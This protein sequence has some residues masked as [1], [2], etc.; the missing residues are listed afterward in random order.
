MGDLRKLKVGIGQVQIIEGRASANEAAVDRMIDRALDAGADV[1]AV[2]ASLTDPQNVRLIGLNDSRID[3]AGNVVV[4]EACGESYRI[5][6]GREVPGC[7]FTLIGDTRPYS[8]VGSEAP[9]LRSTLVVKPVG[10]RDVGGKVFAFDGGSAAYDA[11]GRVI[12]RLSDGFEEDFALV[13]LAEGGKVEGATENKPLEG[14]VATMRRFDELVMP[15]KPKWVIGLSGGLDSSVTASLLV[16]A[17]GP[18]RV[19]GY[20]LATRFNSDATKSNA[21]AIAETLGIRMRNGSIE[22]L[23]VA[24]GNTAVQ[25]GYAPD[26]LSGLVLENA[27]ARTRAQLLSTFAALEGGVVVNNG[28]RVECA[29]GYA[30]LYGD[31]IG[32][33]CPI[34]DL[35]KVQLFDVARALNAVFGFEA[36]PTNLLPV[37]TPDG[38]QWATMPSAELASGQVDPMKWFYHDWLVSELQG[39]FAPSQRTLDEAACNVM[40]RYL[41]DRLE[42]AGVG[43]WVRYY[44]LDDPKAF[45]DDLEWALACMRAATFKGVQAP[46]KI[47]IASPAT[48][49]C[50]GVSQV[51]PEPSSRYHVLMRKLRH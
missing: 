16:T 47:V 9:A 15:W 28:N 46:P 51:A 23:V 49:A 21:A 30:T 22:D 27:Q 2:P 39:D 13:T 24:L 26:A 32:A 44:G 36:V 38:Y 7:D 6:V 33:L 20:N 5:A 18:E 48:I 8:I 31:A 34:A 4:L 19:V 37:E 41:D 1:L 35:T 45:A 17:F 12:A 25:Y 3:I 40:E 42:S 43:K 50:D 14:I 10:M 11:S 29:F